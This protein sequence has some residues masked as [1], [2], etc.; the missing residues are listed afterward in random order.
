VSQGHTISAATEGVFFD[1]TLDPFPSSTRVQT[2]TF[3]S[4]TITASEVSSRVFA[5]YTQTVSVGGEAKSV[6]G[7]EVSAAVTGV[8][9]ATASAS[10]STSST[11]GAGRVW[12]GCW[13]GLGVCG[14]LFSLL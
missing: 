13:A 4:E 7:Q 1:G 2:L 3:E 9:V 8:V 11:S 10:E 14:L 6:L 5:V 12:T